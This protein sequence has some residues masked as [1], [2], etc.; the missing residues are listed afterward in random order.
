VL[1]A[2]ISCSVVWAS[3]ASLDEVTVLDTSTSDVDGED[4]PL[5]PTS[6][7]L[8]ELTKPV[9]VASS[10]TE[11]LTTI[12]VGSV[13]SSV[14]VDSPD[15]GIESTLGS[16]TGAWPVRVALGWVSLPD[17]KLL[18]NWP[19]LLV[20]VAIGD[21]G[22]TFRGKVLVIPGRAEVGSPWEN[23]TLVTCAVGDSWTM[24]GTS[25]E[26]EKLSLELAVAPDTPEVA[27]GSDWMIRVSADSTFV[28]DPRELTSDELAGSGIIAS[29]V[30]TEPMADKLSR[31]V[32]V[33][34]GLDTT[35][36]S[37]SETTVAP[38]DDATLPTISVW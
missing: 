28:D 5:S 12:V 38:E 19:I 20:C 17:N 10:C 21:A 4:V 24:V 30:T 8:E 29:F 34:V 35:E 26:L 14:L 1:D 9:A 22:L 33:P 13:L 16:W 2:E 6:V 11:L 18:E 36:K 3:L 15:C 23:E 25:D 7:W 31:A 27:R 37:D 32:S